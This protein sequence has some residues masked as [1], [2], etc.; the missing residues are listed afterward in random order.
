[1]HVSKNTT[2]REFDLDMSN[3][4]LSIIKDY[5]PEPES[6]FSLREDL[7]TTNVYGIQELNLRLIRLVQL[8]RYGLVGFEETSDSINIIHAVNE[9]FTCELTQKG[10]YYWSVKNDLLPD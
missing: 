1:M 3:S 2:I 9:G 7:L 4:V 10:K 8:M 6:T 5:F